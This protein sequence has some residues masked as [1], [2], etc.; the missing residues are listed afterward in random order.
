M[1]RAGLGVGRHTPLQPLPHGDHH[2]LKR[3]SILHGPGCA[4]KANSGEAKAVTLASQT[5]P[6]NSSSCLDD[7]SQ[8]TKK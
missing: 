2:V 4:Q 7:Q 1:P 3:G 5:A 8:Q 6:A